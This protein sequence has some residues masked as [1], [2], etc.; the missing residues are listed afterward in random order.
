MTYKV[1]ALALLFIRS[2]V[3]QSRLRSIFDNYPD[4]FCAELLLE[5][6]REEN[7]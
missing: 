7:G 5:V 3:A 1:L 2:V 4:E 6:F